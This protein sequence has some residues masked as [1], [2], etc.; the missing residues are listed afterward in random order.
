MF[1][2][3]HTLSKLLRNLHL[4]PEI[5]NRVRALEV[6]TPPLELIAA[7]PLGERIDAVRK[8]QE[9]LVSDTYRVPFPG[10]DLDWYRYASR[11]QSMMFYI[12]LL[13]YLERALKSVPRG[14]TLRLL[15]VGAATGAG[16][17]LYGTIFKSGFLG[18]QI[19]V[20]AIDIMS[21]YKPMS[22]ILN[23]HINYVI[24]D[25]Y[26][27]PE[28][29][30]DFVICSHTIEHVGYDNLVSFISKVASIATRSAIFYAPFEEQN[31]IAGHPC[32]ITKEFIRELQPSWSETRESL[33]WKHPVDEQSQCIV[34]GFDNGAGVPDA[35][36]A[37]PHVM[38]EIA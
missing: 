36:T 5:A 2:K 26:A 1:Q 4:L 6:H 18:Y 11:V 13:P 28:R 31:L 38:T 27:L 10:A 23:S 20:D 19:Q 22:D 37:K 15:D 21:Q 29:S 34:F 14:S 25:V 8:A 17:E 32:R 3:I 24:G 16:S 33:A 9:Q 30:Y 12:D 35:A 7:L